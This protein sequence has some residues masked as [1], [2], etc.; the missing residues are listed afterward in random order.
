MQVSWNG[1]T[2][3]KTEKQENH[4]YLKRKWRKRYGRRKT[5]NHQV[6]T[7]VDNIPAE[8]LKHGGPG[9]IDALTV[10]YQ[11]IWTSGQ[12]P[13][14]G[15]KSPILFSSEERQYTTL[16]E[17]QNDH[18]DLSAQH[19]T[20]DRQQASKPGPGWTNLG[21]GTNRFQMTKRYHGTDIQLEAIGG[22]AP[23][24]PE[25]ALS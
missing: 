9:I 20:S 23:G 14:Y 3:W 18:R 24:T 4:L 11:K 12:W 19:A 1:K 6:L 7:G 16:S 5:A 22:K 21:R 15:T 8:I 17:L 2:T 10:V 13:K 25:G